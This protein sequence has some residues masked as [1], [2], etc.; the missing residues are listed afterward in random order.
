MKSS[1]QLL[2]MLLLAV[3]IYA[4]VLLSI[5]GQHKFTNDYIVENIQQNQGYLWLKLKYV[6]TQS[7]FLKRDNQIVGD[8]IFEF[9]QESENEFR[10]KIYPLT[11][12]R[13]VLPYKLPF[14][15]SKNIQAA[16]ENPLYCFQ[17]SKPDQQFFFKIRRCSTNEL[18]FDTSVGSFIF[19]DK[20]IEFSTVITSDY[21]YG[22]GE[23]RQHFKYQPGT[24]SNWNHGAALKIEHGR[25]NGQ[26]YGFHPMYLRKE[27]SDYFHIG[28]LRTSNAF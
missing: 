9:Y 10:F 16:V 23:R 2:S 3:I 7:T 17:I 19:S 21:F 27:A 18:L 26:M 28:Y 8:L 5:N 14:P 1:W 13:F 6:G 20:Y 4:L 15:F 22:M 11:Q 12:D 25:P 24:Y